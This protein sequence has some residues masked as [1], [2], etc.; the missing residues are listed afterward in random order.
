MDN[1]ELKAK[2]NTETARIAWTELERHFAHGALITVSRGLDLIEVASAMAAD[3]KSAVQA[4]LADERLHRT[5]SEE[6]RRWSE[7][8]GEL[9]CV[10]VAPWVLVQE[11]ADH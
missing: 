7:A 3:D 11:A 6:A 10:V 2:L 5:S 1:D 8:G 4:W 9:W